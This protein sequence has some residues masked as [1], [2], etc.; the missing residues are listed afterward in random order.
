M[1][2]APALNKV[3]TSTLL[4]CAV[5][6]AACT[7]QADHT[8]SSEGDTSCNPCVL[9]PS[10][11][12]LAGT[13]LVTVPPAPASMAPL[14]LTVDGS[15]GAA[16]TANTAKQLS[17]GK[18][19]L[20]LDS[21]GRSVDCSVTIAS[22]AT[23]VVDLGI[24]Q[25]APLKRST[26]GLHFAPGIGASAPS[27]KSSDHL[28]TLSSIAARLPG[29]YHFSFGLFDGVDLPIRGGSSQAIDFDSSDSLAQRRL[30]EIQDPVRNFPG[31]CG[32]PSAD[33]V[34]ELSAS[35]NGGSTGGVFSASAGAHYIVGDFVGDNGRSVITIKIDGTQIG[36]VATAAPGAPPAILAIGRIEID[37]VAVTQSSGAIVK[38]PGLYTIE[39]ATTSNGVKTF[40]NLCVQMPTKSGVDVLPG[41]YR[42]TTTY[43]TV[44][45]GKKTV[46]QSVTVD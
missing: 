43:S 9:N 34:Y 1:N 10:G 24:I 31:R 5:A 46:V 6:G 18:H 37:D 32:N 2:P 40:E 3:L 14:S 42:V 19:C 29:T 11:N 8:A 23:V 41:T 22:S 33:P 35:R 45:A 17:S 38:V 13:L 30:A 39:R 27:F 15:Q 12:D 36:T 25:Y 26:Y 16:V 21:N 4:L 7:T 44:E 20:T 28:D